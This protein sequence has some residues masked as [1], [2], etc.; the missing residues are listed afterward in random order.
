MHRRHRDHQVGGI[1]HNNAIKALLQMPNLGP[2]VQVL[3][4][5]GL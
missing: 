4:A 2:L 5:M 1:G 3:V